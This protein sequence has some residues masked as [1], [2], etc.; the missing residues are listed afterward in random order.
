MATVTT[1]YRIIGDIT[2]EFVTITHGDDI[3][4]EANVLMPEE[5]SALPVI[6]IPTAPVLEP[7][8]EVVP[9]EPPVEIVPEETVPEEV[10]ARPL[11]EMAMGAVAPPPL[12]KKR[13]G[14][15]AFIRGIYTVIFSLLGMM[16]A[17]FAYLQDNLNQLTDIKWQ[18]IVIVVGGALLAGIGYGLKRFWKPE[19]LL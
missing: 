12:T 1:R 17:A 7:P 4:L 19:G 5:T 11:G 9:E 18:T 2:I 6:D 16:G 15:Q 3:T 14:L 10:I 13:R 8:V